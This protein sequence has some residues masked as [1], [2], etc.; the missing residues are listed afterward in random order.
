MKPSSSTRRCL[1]WK[2]VLPQA[3]LFFATFAIVSVALHAADPERPQRVS[4]ESKLQEPYSNSN[5]FT[6]ST[7]NYGYKVWFGTGTLVHSHVG[8]TAAHVVFDD[9]SLYWNN[10]NTFFGKQ[11]T[12]VKTWSKYSNASASYGKLTSDHAY[13]PFN[14]DFAAAYRVGEPISN[15]YASFVV[16]DPGSVSPLGE[17]TDKLIIGFPRDP[18]FVPQGDRAAMHAIGP[19]NWKFYDVLNEIFTRDL[20]PYGYSLA[21][22]QVDNV[23]VYGGISG[24][25]VYIHDPYDNRWL[26]AA[27]VTGGSTP[28][29]K[30]SFTIT[31]EIDLAAHELIES[32]MEA[33]GA[34]YVKRPSSIAAVVE[35]GNIVI[36]WESPYFAHWEVARHDGRGWSQLGVFT[37]PE[38][39]NPELIDTSAEPGT[40]YLYKARAVGLASPTPWSPIVSAQ[41][42]GANRSLGWAVGAPRLS[43]TTGGNAPWYI[44]S[45]NAVSGRIGNEAQSWIET[46]VKGPGKIQ[47]NWQVSSEKAS[48]GT[49]RDNLRFLI[50]GAQMKQINGERTETRVSYNLQAGTH[51]LRWI[52]RKDSS[53]TAGQDR[54]FLSNVKFESSDKKNLIDGGH[55]LAEANGWSYASWF[56][57]YS[58]AS[59][60]AWVWHP[61][62]F[63][64]SSSGW[65]YLSGS[66]NSLWLYTDSPELGWTYTSPDIFPYMWSDA[67]KSWVY[68][69]MDGNWFVDLNSLAYFQP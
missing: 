39:E 52:Y 55:E 46:R 4:E 21:T 28:S 47:F 41:L 51:V 2:H 29:N 45:N 15:Q 40:Q 11:M 53:G 5:T 7:R 1:N 23:V 66:V 59:D 9:R 35:G 38:G 36:R 16:H 22:Y 33:S 30:D 42:A 18:E 6:S 64:G 61:N 27:I 13:W 12:G 19:K 17:D 50:N 3:A 10:E 43:W 63:G 54:A 25:P 62:F 65:V 31:R 67:R 34:G 68:N 20:D 8:L 26:Q 14:L 57:Y 49:V 48:G 24:G 32:A 44:G 56:G 58:P 60:P 69:Y 37:S